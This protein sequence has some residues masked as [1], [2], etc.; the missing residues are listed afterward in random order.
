MNETLNSKGYDLY[1]I[2]KDLWFLHSKGDKIY[3]GTFPT[4]VKK[5]I[6]LGFSLAEVEQAVCDMV[7]KGHNGAHFGMHGS[8]LFSFKREFKY[9]KTG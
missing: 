4:V 2:E 9:A 3:N 1:E 7:S 5:A 8:F 6:E